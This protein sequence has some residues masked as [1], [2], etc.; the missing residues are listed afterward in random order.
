[1]PVSDEERREWEGLYSCSSS[2]RYKEAEPVIE[3]NSSMILF[4]VTNKIN[5]IL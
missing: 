3:L 2:E 5:N 1:M 4:T